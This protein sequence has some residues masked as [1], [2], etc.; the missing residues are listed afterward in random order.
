MNTEYLSHELGAEVTLES[1]SQAGVGVGKDDTATVLRALGRLAVRAAAL[2]N[3]WRER[4]WQRLQLQQLGERTLRD[5]GI[6]RADVHREASK[7]FWQA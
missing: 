3:T 6:T 4:R 5:I 2:L 7:W 1:S